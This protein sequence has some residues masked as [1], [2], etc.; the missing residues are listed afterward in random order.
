MTNGGPFVLMVGAADR[1]KTI[2]TGLRAV[3]MLRDGGVEVAAVVVG[4]APV[5]FADAGWV[6]AATNVT[7]D[8]LAWLYGHA[9]AVLVPSRHEGYGLP[10]VEAL[11]FGTPVV[12]S[13]LPALR[14]V[15]GE[16]ARYA[17][18]GNAA[19][20]ARELVRI[21]DQPDAARQRVGQ[22]ADTARALTWNAT[23]RATIAVYRE[24]VERGS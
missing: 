5:E 22:G 12:A 9:L 18:A 11:A 14:E 7:D 3:G 1:R 21:V 19:A 2:G 15:G 23:V 6:R 16:A 4:S 13:D 8:E 24:L 17:P 10:V 20:F